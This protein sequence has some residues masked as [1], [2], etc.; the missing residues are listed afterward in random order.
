MFKEIAESSPAQEA[1][2]P[3]IPQY[4]LP[5]ILFMF[6][7][8]AV[9]F[10]FLIHVVAPLF[11]TPVPGEFLPTPNFLAVM[12]FG[13]GAELIVALLLLRRER[14][15]LT[16]SGLRDRVRLR[17]PLGWKKWGLGLSCGPAGQFMGGI[18][19]SLDRQLSHALP[20]TDTG[21]FWNRLALL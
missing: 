7:W 12:V 15:K 3:V 14:Y 11:F 2:A 8:P 10:L 20:D 4:S 19:L 18:A 9:W 16:M 6:A 21:G 5:M 17:W 13:N 1:G